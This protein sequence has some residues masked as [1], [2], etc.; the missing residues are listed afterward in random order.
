MAK[1]IKIR[2]IDTFEIKIEKKVSITCFFK[3]ADV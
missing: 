1:D 2:V 3:E